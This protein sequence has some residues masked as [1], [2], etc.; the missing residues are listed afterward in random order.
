LA[1]RVETPPLH[2]VSDIRCETTWVAMRDG[3]RLATDLYFPPEASVGALALRTP[4]DR[5]ARRK[6][7][8]WLAQRGYVVISQDCRGTGAS[9]PDHWD[10]MVYE[11]EDSFDF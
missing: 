1:N 4:Y 6:A 11:R 9:E 8:V 2:D 10:F 7:L 5:S 3:A